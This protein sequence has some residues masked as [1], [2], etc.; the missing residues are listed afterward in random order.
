MAW[1]AVIREGKTVFVTTHPYFCSGLKE[2]G[3]V[4]LPLWELIE[5]ILRM[6]DTISNFDVIYDLEDVVNG[7]FV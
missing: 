1:E 5:V 7:E 2:N 3:K 6:S 4:N